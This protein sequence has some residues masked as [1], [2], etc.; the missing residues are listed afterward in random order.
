MPW[1][2]AV[3]PALETCCGFPSPMAKVRWSMSP[4]TAAI[5]GE[6]F[7]RPSVNT[8]MALSVKPVTGLRVE[9]PRATPA[10]DPGLGPRRLGHEA[11]KA[12]LVP[13]PSR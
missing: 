10:P 1:V 9:R 4:S 13:V 3:S 5:M 12:G 8:T 6:V 11:L 7:S 2:S